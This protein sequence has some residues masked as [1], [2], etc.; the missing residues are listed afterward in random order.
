[1]SDMEQEKQ[2]CEGA[3]GA[4]VFVFGAHAVAQ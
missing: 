3:G 1:M 4:G 2:G